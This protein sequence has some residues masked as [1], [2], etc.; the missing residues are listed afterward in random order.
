[1]VKENIV[2]VF[3]LE[4]LHA[5]VRLLH[6]I[7]ARDMSANPGGPIEGVFLFDLLTFKV[8]ILDDMVIHPDCTAQALFQHCQ[9]FGHLGGDF[10]LG[11]ALGDS[12]EGIDEDDIRFD[13]HS[14]RLKNLVMIGIDEVEDLGL[15]VKE[16]EFRFPFKVIHEFIDSLQRLILMPLH[17]HIPDAHGAFDGEGSEDGGSLCQVHGDLDGD[18]G[19]ALAGVRRHH[20]GIMFVEEAF[21]DGRVFGEILDSVEEFCT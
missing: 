21:Y 14:T 13:G 1:M 7:G 15:G 8:L 12:V 16:E 9:A 20:E 17:L 18:Q 3:L 19:F 6:I 5:G 2:I 10:V 4:E 11:E